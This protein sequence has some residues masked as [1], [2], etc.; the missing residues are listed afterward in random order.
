M[1][2]EAYIYS[3]SSSWG[4]SIQEHDENDGRRSSVRA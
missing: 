3:K 1:N 4:V 2:E